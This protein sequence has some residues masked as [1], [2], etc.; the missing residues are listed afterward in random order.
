MNLIAPKPHKSYIRRKRCLHESSRIIQ[1]TMRAINSSTGRQMTDAEL[2]EFST[3]LA[4]K[5]EASC[6]SPRLKISDK[7]YQKKT[8]EKT[9][10]L[11]DSLIRQNNLPFIHSPGCFNC[12]S[13]YGPII[14]NSNF[15]Q[16]NNINPNF[17]TN[18]PQTPLLMHKESISNAGQIQSQSSISQVPMNNNNINNTSNIFNLSSQNSNSFNSTNVNM[19][20]NVHEMKFNHGITNNINNIKVSGNSTSVNSDRIGILPNQLQNEKNDLNIS[21]FSA[22]EQEAPSSFNN[23]PNIDSS[24]LRTKP[25]DKQFPTQ[26]QAKEANISTNNIY[27]N[28]LL[29]YTSSSQQIKPFTNSNSMFPKDTSIANPVKK[30]RKPKKAS[31]SLNPQ[32]NNQQQPNPNQQY[33]QIQQNPMMQQMMLL[34]QQQMMQLQQ[35][36]MM[37]FQPQQQMNQFQPQIPT[38]QQQASLGSQNF[39]NQVMNFNDNSSLL[40]QQRQ[41]PQI[42]QQQ[43]PKSSNDFINNQAFMSPVSSLNNKTNQQQQQSS[44]FQIMQ[45]SNSISELNG[46]EGNQDD[47]DDDQISWNGS[48]QYKPFPFFDG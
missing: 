9:Q 15:F 13:Y 31:L 14:N 35:Q 30:A 29:P 33:S 3:N 22:E 19:D 17:P 7:E 38:I 36:Q 27:P 16:G 5:I 46:I 39:N 42:F 34:K 43:L 1:N 6:W 41:Q 44:Q 32:L 18:A 11:C 48:K 24:E 47:D 8:E 40:Q 26:S 37:Q 12:N 2:L 45:S 10:Q 23:S 4:R 28:N 20:K 21:D 25:Q